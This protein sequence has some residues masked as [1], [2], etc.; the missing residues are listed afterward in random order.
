MKPD[1]LRNAERLI[2]KMVRCPRLAFEDPNAVS[3]DGAEK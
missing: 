2:L 1:Q 3:R